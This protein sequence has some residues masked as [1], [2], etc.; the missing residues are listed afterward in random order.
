MTAIDMVRALHTAIGVNPLLQRLAI[1]SLEMAAICVLVALFIRVARIRSPRLI[2]ILWLVVLLKPIVSMSVGSALPVFSLGGPA[3]IGSQEGELL[4]AEDYGAPPVE[5]AQ[6]AVSGAER[7]AATILAI[8]AA[9]AAVGICLRLVGRFRLMSIVRGARPASEL[10]ASRYAAVAAEVGVRRLPRLRITDTVESPAITG[11]IRPTILIPGW[12]AHEQNRSK[13]DWSL[14]HELTHW[15]WLDPLVLFIRDLS[16]A[17]FWFH[18]AAPWSG[19]R[20]VESLEQA[21]DRAML[22]D[23]SQASAYA[24][25][26]FGMLQ[27]MRQKRRIAISGGLFATRTQIGK[28][29]AALL[30]ERLR[31]G[32]RASVAAIVLTATLAIAGLC[33]GGVFRARHVDSASTETLEPTAE[34]LV[35]ETFGPGSEF[36]ESLNGIDETQ[37][38]LDEAEANPRPSAGW[39][40]YSTPPGAVGQP[41]QPMGFGGYGGATPANPPQPD[42]AQPA[43]PP[44][45]W[46]GY[47]GGYGGNITTTA[48]AGESTRPRP[49]GAWGFGGYGMGGYSTTRPQ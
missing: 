23:A 46:G 13:L 2:C 12:L 11:L 9:G 14:R 39:G 24:G 16:L 22:N 30:D 5:A 20:L 49:Q 19:R 1:A 35:A 38:H 33:V 15:K 34:D 21:C 40:G 37:D 4:P 17:V 7:L 42:K 36:E 47:G 6:Y 45:M 48:P 26:L 31:P 41:G 3:A 8:W 43:R 32:R 10:L 25:Q 28:R 44:A 18:P 27:E 29:I